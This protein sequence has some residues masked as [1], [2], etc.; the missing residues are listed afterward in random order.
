MLVLVRHAD[1]VATSA[2]TGLEADRPL[3]TLGDRQSVQLVA[4]LADV[5]LSV[6][7]SS[8]TLRCRQ[9]L[10][11]LSVARRLP[12]V[13]HPLLAADAPVGDLLAAFDRAD[14]AALWCTHREVLEQLAG[15]ATE[16]GAHRYLPTAKTA[17]G[18]A[19]IVHAGRDP[20]YIGPTPP[21]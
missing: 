1:A 18:G 12:I 14:D 13:D 20:R 6:L 5:E 15:V 9:T 3:S 4:A 17:K 19:W 21:G 10:Q 2:W 8:P 7:F 11:A 16:H